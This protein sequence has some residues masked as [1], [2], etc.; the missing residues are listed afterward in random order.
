MRDVAAT[1]RRWQEQGLDSAVARVVS[2]HG[3]GGRR[4]GEAL[5]VNAAGETAG[6][7][8][9]GRATDDVVAAAGE[10]LQSDRAAQLVDV[11]LGDTEAVAAG[12]A[13]GGTA[14][15]IVQRVTTFPAAVWAALADRQAVALATNL[16]ESGRT[17]LVPDSEQLAAG[18]SVAEVVTGTGGQADRLVE[19]FV[20]PPLVAIVGAAELAGALSRQAALLGWEA[21]VIDGPGDDGPAAKLATTLTPADALVVLSHDPEVDTPA[22]AAGLRGEAGYVGALGSRHT[23]AGRRTRLAERGVSPAQ[24]AE[25]HGPVGLDLGARAPEEVALAIC[26]E[27]L[28]VKRGRAASSLRDG[29]GPING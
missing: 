17:V 19:T 23:Q 1:I 4:A 6:A 9:G 24:L 13:C 5:A 27:I 26:A 2:W 15:V 7:L 14:R 21:A 22:L 8:I 16:D 18:R 10:L 20:A 12:L 3:F 28:A 11:A 25:I 29:N